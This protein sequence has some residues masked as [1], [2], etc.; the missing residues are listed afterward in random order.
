MT[1]RK[2]S[3]L[4]FITSIALVIILC[5]SMAL[6]V[7]AAGEAIKGDEENPAE[8]AIA[9]V[10][11]MPIGTTT[12]N[13]TFTFNIDIKSVDES[14]DDT[15]LAAA[16]TV[17]PLSVI[18][19]PTDN[20]TV[21]GTGTSAYKSVPKETK[22][23]FAGADWKHAG[24]YIYTITEVQGTLNT[25]EEKMTYSQAEY[26]LW[27]LVQEREDKKGFYVEMIAAYIK[28]TDASNEDEEGSKVDPTP[29]KPDI[30]GN[31]SEMI[32]TNVY[33]KNNGGVDPNDNAVFKLSKHVAGD[34]LD[35]EKY[36]KYAI[37]VTQPI[38]VTGK[39][40]YKAYVMDE[41]NNVVMNIAN[42][43]PAGNIK[44]DASSRPYIEFTSGTEL[45]VSLK[46]GQW[47]SFIDMPV[48]TN[49]VAEESAHSSYVP[50]YTLTL[51]GK[52]DP[53]VTG[54]KN[55][56]LGFGKDPDF[57]YIGEKANSAAFINL[58]EISTPT[59][60]IVDNLPYIILIMVGL[61]AFVGFGIFR[62]RKAQNTMDK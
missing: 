36:F 49:I 57:T 41:N 37:N 4:T 51:D 60:I 11:N 42:N 39:S 56:P 8:A 45:A 20:G 43:A 58:Y 55:T 15:D 34:V 47:L 29:Q 53:Q 27:V 30:T 22:S 21:I 31:Y 59:G 33:L 1:K 17:G 19:K 23:I 5:I 3:K 14:T 28:V 24:M 32:F 9:K 25:F 16:P 18:Y 62:S 46:H 7:F 54:T 48:G 12:P 38:T 40:T 2:N 6:P 35:T 50:K 13:V 52:T 26:E 61:L 10:L 44:P